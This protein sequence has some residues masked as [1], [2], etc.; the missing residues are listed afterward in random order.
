VQIRSPPAGSV[1]TDMRTLN[2]IGQE[3]DELSERRLRVMR[4]LS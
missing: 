3:I 1:F 4:D 2:E